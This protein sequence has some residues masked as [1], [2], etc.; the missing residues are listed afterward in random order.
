MEAFNEPREL[1]LSCPKHEH[2]YLED[3]KADE[4]TFWDCWLSTSDVAVSKKKVR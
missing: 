2:D 4:T 1:L 3:G